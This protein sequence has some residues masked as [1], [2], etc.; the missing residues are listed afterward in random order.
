[1]FIDY[2]VADREPEAGSMSGFFGREKRIEN[3]LLDLG[4]NAAPRVGVI[5]TTALPGIICK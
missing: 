3:L 2:T 4:C 5:P 1:M